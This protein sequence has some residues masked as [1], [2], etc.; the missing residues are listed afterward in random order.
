MWKFSWRFLVLAVLSVFHKCRAFSL[1]MPT[2]KRRMSWAVRA[3]SDDNEQNNDE[4]SGI[5][6]L[7]AIGESSFGSRKSTEASSTH[8]QPL[9]DGEKKEVAFVSDKFELQY[10]CKICDTRNTHRVSRLGKFIWLYKACKRPLALIVSTHSHDQHTHA[11]YRNGVVITV[12]KG[13]ESQHLIADHLGW[14][15]YD[16]GFEGDTNTIEDYF[17]A[18]G[19]EDAVSRVSEDV[20]QLEKLL[21]IQTDSGSIVGEDG[22]LAME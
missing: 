11:A 10:T 22:N 1:L 3:S 2:T 19:Q 4:D 8:H 6:Q 18:K 12:C 5:P 17:V 14:T 13:C 7:P 21:D 9:V 15:D 20:F 16:G